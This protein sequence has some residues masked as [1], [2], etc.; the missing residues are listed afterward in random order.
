MKQCG[1]FCKLNGMRAKRFARDVPTRWNSTFKFLLSTFEYKDLLCG[2]FGQIVQSSNIY[3][4]SNQ[5]NICTTICEILKVFNDATDQLSDVYY[6]T[7]HLVVT[8]LCNIACIFSEHLNS[9]DPALIEC[10]IIRP[11][12]LEAQCLLNDWSRVASRTQDSQNETNDDEDTEGISK[13]QLEEAQVISQV[14]NIIRLLLSIV[15]L[16]YLYYYSIT[17]IF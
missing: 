2:F 6:P 17:F 9:N 7:C 13:Q 10:I 5:W 14:P 15:I 1:K 4:Y 3:L 11:E 12:N 16:T 8:H